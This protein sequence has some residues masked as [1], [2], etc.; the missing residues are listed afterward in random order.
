M[1]LWASCF[2]FVRINFNCLLMVWMPSGSWI[3]RFFRSSYARSNTLTCMHTCMHA[4]TDLPRPS[5]TFSASARARWARLS[6]GSN[7]WS[8]CSPHL[9]NNNSPSSIEPLAR[10]TPTPKPRGLL[11]DTTS[12]GTSNREV[13]VHLWHVAS[14]LGLGNACVAGVLQ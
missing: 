7:P 6:T 13:K 12:P 2:R 14:G 11:A 4:R 5:A 1:V 10:T 9:P 8:E 3:Y